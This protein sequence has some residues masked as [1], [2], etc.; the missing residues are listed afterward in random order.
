MRV[1]NIVAIRI[2]PIRLVR[3]GKDARH[4]SGGGG[5]ENDGAVPVGLTH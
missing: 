2:A 1:I 5:R 4:T 3:C